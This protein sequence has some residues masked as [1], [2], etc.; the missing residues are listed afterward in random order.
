MAT[1]FSVFNPGGEQFVSEPER[2]EEI[3]RQAAIRDQMALREL[4]QRAR[5]GKERTDAALAQIASNERIAGGENRTALELQQ[6][7][8][9][10]ARELAEVTGGIKR[11]IA[12]IGANAQTR[13][14]E[15]A[16]GP[17]QTLAD[18]EGRRFDASLPG[19]EAQNRLMAAQA[20]AE[21]DKIGVRRALLGDILGGGGLPG[22]DLGD[23]V[24]SDVQTAFIEDEFGVDLPSADE[25]K[26]KQRTSGAQES[27]ESRIVQDPIGRKALT[28]AMAVTGDRGAALAAAQEAIQMRN[29]ED[30]QDFVVNL[31]TFVN[32]DDSL[33]P[34]DPSDSEVAAMA[35]LGTQIMNRL[36]LTEG[37]ASGARK[38]LAQA[39]RPILAQEFGDSSVGGGS[40]DSFADQTNALLSR[41]G[42][43]DL[44]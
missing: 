33:L 34:S 44:L 18:L 30:L 40:G 37:S 10:N 28:N 16:A 36:I 39:I 14:A 42:I 29:Q 26:A 13:A 27:L 3:K 15:I 12:G 17:N 41:L 22:G 21:R 31:R 23:D 32:S 25:R 11:D 9:T 24:R 19:M 1:R 4:A 2:F 7:A 35:D 43:L 6:Q 8:G 5:L 38:R 20:D